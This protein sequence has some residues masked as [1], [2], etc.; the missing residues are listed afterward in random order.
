MKHTNSFNEY[1]L[2]CPDFP[3]GWG[4]P[5]KPC[6]PGVTRLPL[7]RTPVVMQVPCLLSLGSEQLSPADLPLISDT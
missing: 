3:R 5:T 4:V 6:I 1:P 7:H 2:V